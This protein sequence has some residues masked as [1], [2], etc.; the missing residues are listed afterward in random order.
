MNLLQAF[1]P[2]PGEALHRSALGTLI[3]AAAVL[4]LASPPTS[5]GGVSTPAQVPS[6]PLCLSHTQPPFHPWD[7]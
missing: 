6:F 1:Q 4:S 3:L 5:C 2:V 7:I